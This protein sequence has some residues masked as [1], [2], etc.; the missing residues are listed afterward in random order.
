MSMS[1]LLVNNLSNAI[2]TLKAEGFYVVPTTTK[3]HKQISS[4][5]RL[6]TVKKAAIITANHTQSK[7]IFKTS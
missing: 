7:I 5:M 1:T 4:R 3:N 6:G 2:K